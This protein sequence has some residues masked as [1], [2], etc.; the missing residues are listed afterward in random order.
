MQYCGLKL[1]DYDKSIIKALYVYGPLSAWSIAKLVKNYLGKEQ[2]KD[3]V[4]RT[5]KI[6]AHLV[7]RKSG[8]LRVLE[9]YKFIEQYEDKTWHLTLRGI[10]S[11]MKLYPDIEINEKYYNMTFV[12]SFLYIPIVLDNIYTSILSIFP[13]KEIIKEGDVDI[14]NRYLYSL[15]KI[16]IQGD[17]DDEYLCGYRN[18]IMDILVNATRHYM[19]LPL[20]EKLR[21]IYDDMAEKHRYI[22]LNWITQV[23]L[24]LERIQIHI[25]N[26]LVKIKPVDKELKEE[27]DL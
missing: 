17:E 12:Y 1:A 8:R 27:S 15:M 20:N 11:V 25:K 7:R 6:Y 9:R 14:S 22:Y 26:I 3:V 2:D 21:K 23:K 19:K 10:M 18:I 4:E 5:R 24:I 16:L 13:S